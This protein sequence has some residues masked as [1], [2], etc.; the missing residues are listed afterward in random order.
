MSCQ[1][2]PGR[3]SQKFL[4]TIFLVSPEETDPLIP[5]ERDLRPPT[6]STSGPDRTGNGERDQRL[7]PTR[8]AGPGLDCLPEEQGRIVNL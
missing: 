5:P 2:L 6:P 3:N 1:P 8:H 7:D 4:P